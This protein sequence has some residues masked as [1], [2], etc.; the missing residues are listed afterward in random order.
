MKS[1]LNISRLWEVPAGDIGDDVITVRYSLTSHQSNEFPFLKYKKYLPE[2][3][4]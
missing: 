2:P 3:W 1:G 4:E